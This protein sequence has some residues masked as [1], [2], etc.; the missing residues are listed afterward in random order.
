MKRSSQIWLKELEAELASRH[1]L[2]HSFYEKWAEGALSRDALRGYTKEYCQLVDA[3]PALV[4]T[5]QTKAPTP[6]MVAGL[7][8]NLR[9]EK[10]HPELWLRF[11][12]ALGLSRRDFLQHTPLP[13]TTEAV[14]TLR[15][16]VEDRSFV[17]GVAALWG[18]ESQVPEVSEKKIEGL[19]TF[20]GITS[21]RGLEYFEVHRTIDQKHTA[22]EEN[23]LVSEARTPEDRKAVES[24]AKAARDAVWRLLDGVYRHHVLARQQLG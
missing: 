10:E 11:G 12:E 13:E 22:M 14:S 8:E 5:V 15:R 20:Y 24:A 7:G 1:L 19:T 17:E 23:I 18:F 2:H 4:R 9:E 3:I 21:P 6:E 16:I